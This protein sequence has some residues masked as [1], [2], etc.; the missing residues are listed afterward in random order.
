MSHDD[1]LAERE[2]GRI[3]RAALYILNH[4]RDGWFTVDPSFSDAEEYALKVT[5]WKDSEVARRTGGMPAYP[6]V[7]TFAHIQNIRA[8]RA[9]D[10]LLDKHTYEHTVSVMLDELIRLW[11]SERGLYRIAR[12]AQ[13][14]IEG[15]ASELLHGLAYLDAE[16][17]PRDI[18]ER[19]VLFS[20][21]LETSIGYRT[22]DGETEKEMIDPYH[23]RTLWPYEQAMIHMA[24][25][26]HNLPHVKEVA[27]RII[28]HIKDGA[29]EIF[30]VDKEGNT[31]PDGN[32]PQLWTIGAREYFAHPER[33][34]LL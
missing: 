22:V 3:E 17:V 2:K 1:S 12:D 23:A 8:L 24:A 29:P 28:P 4:I 32:D 13:G 31:K 14:P 30:V 9:A 25:R 19:I 5:Y 6:A 7:Y 16:D 15:V 21:P 26:K 11:R 33:E 10:T 20:A 18:V 27:E 34:I